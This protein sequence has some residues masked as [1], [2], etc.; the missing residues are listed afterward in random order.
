MNSHVFQHIAPKMTKGL[1]RRGQFALALLFVLVS[2]FIWRPVSAASTYTFSGSSFPSCSN[3]SWTLS[4]TTWTCQGATSLQNGD[5]ILP[6]SSVSI[7]AR[8]G[9]TL[10]RNNDVG[11]SSVTVNLATQWGSLSIGNGSTVY[12]SISSSSGAISLTG[13]TVFGDVTT[14][15]TLTT[16]GG[17][18]S[19][20]VSANNGVTS[21]NGTVF[22]GSVSASNGSISLSGGSVV[23][24]V[25][26]GCCQITTS[27]TN[28][29]GGVSS[30][31]NSVSIT[32]GTVSGV[33]YSSGGNGVSITNA[34]VTSGSISTSGVPITITG[35]LIGS[36]STSVSVTSNN[37]VTI[38]TSTIYGD[39]TAGAWASALS[40][41]SQ[42]TIYGV[43]SSNSNSNTNPSQ[44]PRCVSPFSCSPPANTPAGLALTCVCDTFD[45]AALN[46][47]PIFGS[48]WI[49]STSDS[50]GIVPSIVNS[51]YL[52]LTNN[53]GNN[54]KAATVPGIF[55]AS[56]NYISVEFQHFAYNG[57]GAD[58]IAV[59]LSDYS[60]PPVPGAFGGSL[61]YAQKTGIPGF[62]G[63]WLG[64]ALDEYG[65]YQNP[66][67]G[68]I[69]GPGFRVQ[70]VGARGSGSGTSGY[71]WLGGTST[72]S[73]EVDNN[74]SS[75][76][77]RGHYYQVIVDARAE[78]GAT[79][80]Q[81]NRDTGSGYSSLISIPNVY[82]AA[83][84]NGFTQAPVPAN[85]QI[86]LT[87]STG[88]STNIHEIA[89]LRICAQTVHPPSGGTASS[90]NAIDEAYGTPPLAVQNYL[91]GHIY[92]KLVGV[93]FKL[94]VAA[95]NNNQI[96]TAYV[97]SGSKN[98]TV[99]LVDNSDNVCELDST[100]PNYCNSTCRAKP[101]V[102]GGSQ[103]L[104]FAAS[105][106]GQKQ[107]ANFTLNT[108]YKQL[109]AIVTDGTTTACS[110]DAF[111]VRP[112][113]IASV[114]SSNATNASTS[115][116]PIFKAGA[117][118]FALTLTTTGVA[119]VA[120]GYTGVAK[121]GNT[122]V[123]Y[124]DPA[125]EAGS[126]AST[127]PAA[128][129]GIGSSTA[130]GTTFT[131]SEVGAFAL[132]GYDPNDDAKSTLA[133][134]VYDDTWSA[135]DS[136]NTRN[137][138][139][140]D[141]YSNKKS[142]DGKYGCNFGLMAI[143]GSF[144]RFIPYAFVA[145]SPV[146]TNRKL[147]AC[148]SPGA[149]F[150]YLDEAMG[151]QFTLQAREGGGNVTKNYAGELAKLALTADGAAMNFAAA[152]PAPAFLPVANSRIRGAGFPTAWS[153][154][155]AVFDGTVTVSSLNTAA[156]NRAG[157]DGPFVNLALGIAPVDSDGVRILAYDLDADNSGGVGGPDH[158]TLAAT[159]LY[160]GQ[161]RLIPAIGSELLPLAMRAELLR[162]NGT[163]FVP[164]GDDSCTKIPLANLGLSDWKGNLSAGETA[165][166]PGGL[167]LAAGVGT[168]RL[169]APGAG[170]NGSV[171]VTADVNAA[172]LPYLGGHWSGAKYDQN[173]SALASFGLYKGV[174]KILH[175]RENY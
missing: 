87:G 45:R 59:T 91:T 6:S 7:V 173:P 20:N 85:W 4:G 160:F 146:L 24:G 10:A 145:D 63:G 75:T 94:N 169:S 155:Q 68:R 99:K 103:T 62:A 55:P 19:G 130:T 56:G 25:S 66:T 154:G 1:T 12:G 90:F 115:G 112:T 23:S 167:N 163:A 111:S 97:V 116:T 126:L 67:E 149:T 53:T 15:G 88:G 32:G 156:D 71:R 121:I 171:K 13:T 86:S 131:Y 17:S 124:V 118:P 128:T 136:V 42:S 28:I 72:L 2:L 150:S 57:T 135:V 64:V 50:T 78:P 33:I 153:A 65:N 54:A 60:V 26:S 129:S 31:S 159:T 38:N 151:L 21:T 80:V 122:A 102:S 48:N 76:P 125:T 98:V 152:V 70:S 79:S 43:C 73:P 110:T 113:G 82:A 77:S 109:A 119:G 74:G 166:T 5:A 139:I 39:V 9:M 137:D 83:A 132:A 164:N 41:D 3:G 175:L 11:S 40:I 144:G 95:L 108:A 29:S 114:T 147:A 162:W 158:K 84:A 174:G 141:S 36:S 168:I 104:T 16:S 117:D 133:R 8:G 100:T 105:N 134:G 18:I 142:A 148:A 120:S 92:M 22:G 34:T 58:G 172:G 61:G 106:A 96:Q 46:P 47:S 138:C 37:R 44:Y 101:A 35:S 165:I 51:G 93:P 81:V 140:Q 123:L 49:V 107:S 14:S 52:R 27:N 30:T 143:T 69:G 89:G 161:L 127:F 157:P 170:N